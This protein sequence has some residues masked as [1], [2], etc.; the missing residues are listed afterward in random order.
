MHSHSRHLGALTLVAS[1]GA[2][3]LW[4]AQ[5]AGAPPEEGLAHAAQDDDPA[6]IQKEKPPGTQ[7]F[8]HSKHVPEAWAARLDNGE[9]QFDE[10]QRDCRGCHNYGADQIL[11][12]QTVCTQCHFNNDINGYEFTL[13]ADPPQFVNDLTGL[14]SPG[15]LFQHNYHLALECRECHQVSE[16]E[17]Q[18]PILMP[19]A[20]DKESCRTCHEGDKP[21]QTTLLF[22]T[23]DREGM[24][25][26]ADYRKKAMA[27]LKRNLLTALNRSPAMGP[28]TPEGRFV[29]PFQHADHVLIEGRS[30][31]FSLSEL[32]GAA[33]SP[34]DPKSS[35]REGNCGA[36]HAPMFELPPEASAVDHAPFDQGDQNCGSCHVSDASGTPIQF[37]LKPQAHQSLTAG[38]F[39]HGT[40]LSFVRPQGTPTKSSAEGYNAIEAQG[41]MACHEWDS[42]EKSGFSLKGGLA[43]PDSFRGCQTC[44]TTATWAPESHGNWWTHEDHGDWTS[45]NGCHDP[46]NHDFATNRPQVLVQRRPTGLFTI[47]SHAHPV[48]TVPEGEDIGG[49]CSECHRQPVQELPSRLKNVAFSHQTHL[50]PEAGPESC[51]GCHASVLAGADRSDDLGVLFTRERG[52]TPV[53]ED[54]L[55]LV[56]DPSACTECH[57]GS[58]PVPAM[59]P[60]SVASAPTKEVPQFSHQ[61]HMGKLL[62][63][64]GEVGCN[65]CHQPQAGAPV[66]TLPGAKNCTLCHDHTPAAIVGHATLAAGGISSQEVS[67]CSLCH[68]G[69]LKNLEQLSLLA[70]LHIEDIEGEVAQYHNMEQECV[71]CHLPEAGLMVSAVTA[72]TN[73]RLFANRT[74]FLRSPSDPEVPAIHRGGTRKSQDD[75]DCFYCHW[76]GRL[77]SSTAGATPTGD[78]ETSQIR[79][80]YGM[81]LSDFPGGPKNP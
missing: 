29:G 11:D 77:S 7:N 27:V 8:T 60:E 61:D 21:R 39:F 78:P 13:W 18:P 15:A 4:V 28:N 26:D 80:S 51:A 14:R 67:A 5:S 44:H 16:D 34:G 31:S 32:K 66:G 55:G 2:S 19:G 40:H 50:P 37:E 68:Q 74:M 22:M 73:S 63:G 9:W 57:L 17:F 20:R 47:E 81:R 33:A 24:P 46:D 75:T 70:T 42:R 43:N 3:V 52:I 79:T 56:Y 76:T 72:P 48:I 30:K 64:G 58:A 59:G 12:P 36:C 65:H 54:R 35:G 6:R 69:G 45:C 71:Q 49:S 1:V 53:P 38:T 41:C 23:H 10:Q 25:I 62:N